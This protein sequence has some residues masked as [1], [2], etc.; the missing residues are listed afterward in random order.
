MKIVLLQLDIVPDDAAANI[1]RAQRLM[2]ASPGADLYVLPEMWATG[3]CVRPDDNTRE[4]S[5]L[6]RRWMAGQARRRDC[7]VAGSLAVSGDD[8]R[9]CNAFLFVRPDGSEERYCKRHLFGFGGEDRHYAA[10]TA[11]T[12]VAF[13]GLRFLLQVCYDLR[14][15]VFARNRSDYDAILYVAN[16]PESRITVWDILLRARAVENQCY[17]FGVNR[18]GGAPEGNYSGHSVAIDAYGRPVAD[19]P[20]GEGVVEVVPDMERLAAFRRKFPV[21]ADADDF[22]LVL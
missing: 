5:L 7:A 1:L 12:V 18:T 21:L 20:D 14:F 17:V 9:W 22:E 6:A 2:D 8:G 19:M 15:P 11:R 13:R 4:C 16:W 10:G 3:F